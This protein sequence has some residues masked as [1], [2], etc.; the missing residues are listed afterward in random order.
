MIDRFFIH[1]EEL[2]KKEIRV[3]RRSPASSPPSSS[4]TVPEDGRRL[5]SSAGGEAAAF[6]IH[7]TPADPASRA[8]PHY[9]HA[10]LSRLAAVAPERV[11]VIYAMSDSEDETLETPDSIF[12]STKQKI[13]DTKGAFGLS[14]HRQRGADR[15]RLI[16][17]KFQV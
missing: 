11:Q 10:H 1:G 17:Y 3:P 6:F 16:K 5:P 15:G 9:A 4:A 8:N 2:L 7:P 13:A 12:V 14:Y